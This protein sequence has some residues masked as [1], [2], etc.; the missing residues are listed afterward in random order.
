MSPT[1]QRIESLLKNGS[2]KWNQLRQEGKIAEDYTGATFVQ[3]FSAN[4]NLAELCLAGS[5]W[6]ACDLSRVSFRNTDLSNAYFHGGRLQDCDFRNAQLDGATFENLKLVRCNFSGAK[7]LKALELLA[8]DMDAVV[9][10]EELDEEEDEEEKLPPPPPTP[11]FAQNFRPFDTL[12][13]LFQKGLRRL[14][15]I[16]LWVLDVY[17]LA[18]PLPSQAPTTLSPEG[19]LRDFA[20]AKLTGPK[21]TVTETG[22]QRAQAAL[23]QN[24]A[25]VACAIV[26]LHRMGVAFSCSETVLRSLHHAFRETIE[27]DDLTGAVDP[28]LVHALHLSGA[29]QELLGS[30]DELRMRLSAAQLF[31]ALLQAELSPHNPLWKEAVENDETATS[32]SQMAAGGDLGFLEEAFRIFAGLPEEIQLQRLAYLSVSTQIVEGLLSKR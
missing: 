9:G 24:N 19:L 23:T 16:P 32:L 12:E 20:K 30:L 28:R 7:G 22:L 25:D 31:T 3:L 27:V 4:A 14:E 15:Q 21:P 17:E 2:K 8:V 10:L 1:S 11:A 6:E 5:E 29:K 18:P 13:Q 26:Y